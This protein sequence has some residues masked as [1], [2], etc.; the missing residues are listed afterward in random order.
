MDCRILRQ[1]TL[2]ADG[3]LGCDDSAGYNIDLGHVSLLRGW[4]LRNV[5]NGPV[6]SHVRRSFA[7]NVVPWPGVCEKCDLFSDG[8]R[9]LDTLDKRIDLLVE[10]TLACTLSC[11][12]CMRRKVIAN[13]RGTSSLKPALLE[14]LVDSCNRDNILVGQVHYIGQGEPL[15]HDNFRALFDAVKSGAPQAKQM[16]TTTGNVDFSATVGDAALHTLVVSCDGARQE[17]YEK[18]RKGGDLQT[19]IKFMR[20]SKRVGNA[21][22]HLEWKYIV[23]DHNDSDDELLLTQ[24]IADD[25]GVDSLL[26]IIT[27]SKGKSNRYTVDNILDFPIRSATARVSPSAA[28]NATVLESA[29]FVPS[30]VG[31]IGFGWIDGCSVSAGKILTV[32]GWALDRSG[33]YADHVELIV[34]GI[35]VAR[36]KTIH[37]RSDVVRKVPAAHGPDCG[38]M[39]W[40]PID[41]AALPSSVEI[42][43]VGQ[44]G[45]AKLGG[46]AN[47]SMP[48]IRV[49]N[50][51][52]LPLNSESTYSPKTMPPDDPETL[53]PAERATA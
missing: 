23:F 1:V 24:N 42:N 52:E 22:V 26:F 9:L 17:V 37:T 3:H 12:C 51:P 10:P 45:T 39:F 8:A 28:M 13:G 40:I 48:K 30:D 18:Y 38:F 44:S 41:P 46:M 33:S 4:R 29:G 49:K 14:R 31:S 43:I 35:L 25:I 2:K 19:V 6:Y 53:V 5:L 7:G 27:N 47:W 50:R 16:V 34:D 20:D 15:R 21:N 11:E 36:A 32:I